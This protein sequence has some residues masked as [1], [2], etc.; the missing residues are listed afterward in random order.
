MSDS[1]E[2]AV[3]AEKSPTKQKS[4]EEEAANVVETTENG[5]GEDKPGE[6]AA[7]KDSATSGKS[8]KEGIGLGSLKGKLNFK[9]S[10]PQVPAFL[11]RYKSKVIDYSYLYLQSQARQLFTTMILQ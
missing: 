10:M 6:Q 9:V 3:V 5:A 7:E 1:Q 4:I 8:A 11:K 2:V